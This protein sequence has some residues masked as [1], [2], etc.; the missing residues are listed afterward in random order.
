MFTENQN[1]SHQRTTSSRKPLNLRVSYTD[2]LAFQLPEALRFV[3]LKLDFNPTMEF[4]P[5]NLPVGIPKTL[6]DEDGNSL[7]LLLQLLDRNAEMKNIIFH[8]DDCLRDYH[9]YILAG[10]EFISRPEYKAEGLQVN[11]MGYADGH[12]TLL[13]ERNYTES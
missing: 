1:I 9:K 4:D 2:E 6:L 13:E 3:M 7:T 11:F 12:Y 10:V 5:G 8:T